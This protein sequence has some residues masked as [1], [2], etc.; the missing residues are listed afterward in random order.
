MTQSTHY[1]T[2]GIRKNP[3]GLIPADTTH[4]NSPIR[5]RE[6]KRE[7]ALAML[8]MLDMLYTDPALDAQARDAHEPEMWAVREPN[9]EPYGHAITPG[10]VAQVI[11]DL[12]DLTEA[13]IRMLEN[14][15]AK[16]A[17]SVML[18]ERDAR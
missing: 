14:K 12:I 16:R 9:G 15:R 17:L 2:P 10:D 5:V 8:E 6:Q 13:D 3:L 4:N 18:K 11:A 7:R 1:P